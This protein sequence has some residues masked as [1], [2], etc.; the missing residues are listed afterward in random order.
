MSDSEPAI[1]PKS[2]AEE[3]IDN[4]PTALEQAVEAVKGVKEPVTLRVVEED[5]EI[6]KLLLERNRGGDLSH[7][8]YKPFYVTVKRKPEIQAAR[9]KLPV[10]G[11]EQVIMEAIRNNTVVIIC[12]ETGSGKTTQVPQFLYEAGFSH[13]NSRKPL[14]FLFLTPLTANLTLFL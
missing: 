3:D 10:C 12:G 13:P 14:S 4:G 7:D 2:Q 5:D 1:K 9:L 6:K 11:E 8:D